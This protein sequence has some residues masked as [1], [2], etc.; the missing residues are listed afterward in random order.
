MRVKSSGSPDK[1]NLTF[2]PNFPAMTYYV[3]NISGISRDH[4][5]PGVRESVTESYDPCGA[6]RV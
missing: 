3:E 5:S 1:A 4:T 6:H 2:E